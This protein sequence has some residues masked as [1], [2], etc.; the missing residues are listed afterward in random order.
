[1]P[2][3]RSSWAHAPSS[4]IDS[5]DGLLPRCHLAGALSDS[6]SSANHLCQ[7]RGLKHT[8]SL[9]DRALALLSEFSP[10]INSHSLIPLDLSGVAPVPLDSVLLVV[11]DSSLEPQIDIDDDPLWAEAMA[12]PEREFWISDA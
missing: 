2:L 9:D 1:M 4:C 8:S 7:L 3:H 5:N 10:F 6:S 12:S 11:T